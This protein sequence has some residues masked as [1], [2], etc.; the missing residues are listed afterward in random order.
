M[1]AGRRLRSGGGLDVLLSAR[2]IAPDGMAYGLDMT[3]DMLE[4]AERNRAEAGI[5]N[6][7]FLKG[8]IEDIPLP[9]A[10]VDTLRSPTA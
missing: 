10:S 3:D 8:T 6:A 9:E 5:T 1:L 7:T 4:L 2:R